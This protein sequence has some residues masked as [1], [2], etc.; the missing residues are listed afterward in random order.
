MYTLVRLLEDQNHTHIFQGEL[1]F[2]Q[3]NK[4]ER[5]NV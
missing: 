4:I 3:R 5:E 1:F 2:F